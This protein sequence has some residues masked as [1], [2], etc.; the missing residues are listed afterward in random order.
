MLK[1]KK[2]EKSQQKRDLEIKI[3]FLIKVIIFIKN[4][5][6]YNLNMISFLVIL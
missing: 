5:F 6:R 2:V 4:L 3:F 1:S